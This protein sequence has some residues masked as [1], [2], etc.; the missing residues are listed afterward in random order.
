MILINSIV[1]YFIFRSG[2]LE[3]YKE[4]EEE[5]SIFWNKIIMFSFVSINVLKN[6][7]YYRDSLP[8]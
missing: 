4:E 3:S 5:N 1:I 7:M 8:V 2:P 6:K